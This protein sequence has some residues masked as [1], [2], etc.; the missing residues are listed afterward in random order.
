MKKLILGLFVMLLISSCKFKKSE[1]QSF[2]SLATP[3]DPVQESIEGSLNAISG[4]ADDASSE[5]IIAKENFSIDHLFIA[6]AHA[7][8]CSRALINQGGGICKREVLCQFG[9]FSWSGSVTLAFSNGQN[10]TLGAEGESFNRQVNFTRSGRRGNLTTS[11]NN[12][13][14][15][16]GQSI[17]GGSTVTKVNGGLELEIIGQSKVLKKNNG[18]KVFDISIETT[19]PIVTNQLMRNGRTISS[20]TVQV[21]HNLAKFTA[22][23]SLE[24]L[25]WSSNCCYP[26]SGKVFS[27]LSGSRNETLEIEFKSCGVAQV[28]S[29]NGVKNIELE[30]CE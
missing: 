10:C 18:Q 16:L 24:N 19:M 22:A 26:V 3:S 20:G 15:Y 14:N 29:S 6:K 23:H 1:D 5:S 4:T 8:S 17:G 21:Y 12:Q 27:T 2:G 25:T 13:E 30:Y 9:A 28:T 11:S 7:A